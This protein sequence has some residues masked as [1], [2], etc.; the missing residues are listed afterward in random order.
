MLHAA[1][2]ERIGLT[3]GTVSITVSFVLL[4]VWVP[5]RERIGIGTVANSIWVGVSIDLGMLVLPE[6]P[7]CRSPWR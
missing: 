3:V 4:L 1:I 2:A 5:L 7:Q 6:A